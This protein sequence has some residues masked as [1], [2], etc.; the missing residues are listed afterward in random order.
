M[1][2]GFARGT[3][4][5]IV[6]MV[7]VSG[8][9]RAS[10]AVSP[11]W[12]HLSWFTLSTGEKSDRL[13]EGVTPVAVPA[14]YFVSLQPGVVVSRPL[15]TRTRL[16]LDGMATIERF[17]GNQD[18]FLL[19]ISGSADLARRLGS[20]WRV[21]ATTSAEYVSDSVDEQF[22]RWRLGGELAMGVVGPRGYA[23]V[24]A[25]VQARD[26]PDA[27]TLDRL[28][29]ELQ[30]QDQG[31]WFGATAMYR[32]VRWLEFSGVVT[33]Q[34]TST[35]DPTFDNQAVLATGSLRCFPSA[36]LRAYFTA[37]ILRRSFEDWT[38][39]YA[40]QGAGLTY[41]LAGSFDVSV[42]YARA[43]YESSYE[44]TPDLWRFSLVLTWWS[45]GNAMLA[46]I[47][48]PQGVQLHPLIAG[49]KQRF[50]LLAPDAR[51]VALVGDFNGWNPTRHPM[52][53]SGG[54]WWQVW[55]ALPSGAHQYAYWV[56]GATRTPP[57]SE[58]TVDD[59]FG[60]RNGI[61]HVDP[62][63]L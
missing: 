48:V 3:V 25:G 16:S 61:V 1:A 23:E 34:E 60:G 44:S 50:R 38:D 58:V 43:Q 17:Y 63:S 57:E 4:A 15:G 5:I 41:P 18:G 32:P 39:T 22:N 9:P 42:R 2:R 26:F 14:E 55:V 31:G 10:P 28:G 24:I 21:R 59:G 46:P 49:E 29:R 62:S 12:T 6:V 47:D 35:R 54:G 20:R 52:T 45:G 11:A 30:F 33:R 13:Q 37:S 8:R 27:Y 51:S 36:S 19:G 56:D 53:P 40:Q 7:V